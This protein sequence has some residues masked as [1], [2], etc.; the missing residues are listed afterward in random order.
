MIFGIDFDNTIVKYD[1]VFYTVATEKGLISSNTAASK[2]AVRDELRA[3]G[4]EEAW[5]EMQGYVY[6]CRMELAEIY[7]GLPE[8]VRWANGAGH[9]CFI[10]SHKTQYPYRGPKYDLHEAA[11]EWIN[12]YLVDDNGP[13]FEFDHVSFHETKHDKIEQVAA[14]NCDIFF[15]DL[16]EIFEAANFPSKTRRILFDPDNHHSGNNEIERLAN[17]KQ[18]KALLGE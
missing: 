10:I 11:S 8:F 18:I 13:L 15:D 12:K 4:Q 14:K 2:V 1:N 5:I 16:P 3:S 17:W 6:G 7:A 9:E